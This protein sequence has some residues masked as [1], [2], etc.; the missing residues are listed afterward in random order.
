MT[1]S[2]GDQETAEGSSTQALFLALVVFVTFGLVLLVLSRYGPAGLAR[3]ADAVIGCLGLV[4][5]AVGNVLE[6]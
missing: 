3:Q 2:E 4:P 1:G 6:R 5:T